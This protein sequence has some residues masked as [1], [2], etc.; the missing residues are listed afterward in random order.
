M[1]RP[2]RV[3]RRVRMKVV[4]LINEDAGTSTGLSR[5]EAAREALR[6][7]GVEADVRP[8]PGHELSGLARAA[9][10]EGVDVVIAAG[11][12]GTVGAVADALAG[13]GVVLGVLP[14]GTLNHFARDLGLPPRPDHAARVIAGALRAQSANAATGNGAGSDGFDGFVRAVDLGEVNGRRFVNNASIGLYPHI[15][16]K[17][18]RQQERLGRNKWVAMLV[19]IVAV[20]RRYPLLRVVLDLGERGAVPRVTPFLFVGNNRYAMN[21]LSAGSRQRLD[22]GE[23]CLYFTHRTGR[24]GLFRLALRALFG[25]LDQ[26]KDFESACLPD[27]AVETPKKTLKLALDGEVTRLVPP[28]QFR[29]QPAALRVIAA[30]EAPSPP[31][32]SPPPPSPPP[33]SPPPPSPRTGGVA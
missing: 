2:S 24:F 9:V 7:A 17:R 19:A 4:A 28:L 25:R 5:L 30:A 12:D 10:D 13:T 3:R 11:G 26:A 22:G 23:L 20:F 21:G 18:R 8:A 14:V 29:I 27:F 16:S 33:P 31:S 15:V 32:P 1:A 6:S